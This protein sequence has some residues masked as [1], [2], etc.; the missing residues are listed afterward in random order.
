MKTRILFFSLL[1]LGIFSYGSVTAEDEERDV[2][3]FSEIAL[4]IPANV[5]LVQGNNQSD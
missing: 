1:V 5:Y 4:R 3:S 2:S